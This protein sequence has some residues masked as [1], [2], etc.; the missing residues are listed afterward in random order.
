MCAGRQGSAW[1][2]AA[3]NRSQWQWQHR[4]D[5]AKSSPDVPV[6]DF[7][8]DHAS[9]VV[10]QIR[11]ML[12]RFLQGKPFAPHERTLHGSPDATLPGRPQITGDITAAM[13]TVQVGDDVKTLQAGFGQF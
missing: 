9:H 11:S 2:W 4:G 10:T 8:V 12:K 6:L 3:R 7:S 1:A 13:E 5:E